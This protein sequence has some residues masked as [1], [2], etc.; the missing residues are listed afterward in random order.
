VSKHLFFL[1]P[2]TANTRLTHPGPIRDPAIWAVVEAGLGITA[3]GASMLRPLF[4]G[5]FGGSSTV[6]NHVVNH[7]TYL[8]TERETRNPANYRLNL[9]EAGNYEAGGQRKVVEPDPRRW[10]SSGSRPVLMLNPGKG[11]SS[12]EE[13]LL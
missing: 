13:E 12:S 9:L 4:K 5:L 11:C 3:A 10:N 1:D 2:S 7:P 8:S 6:D